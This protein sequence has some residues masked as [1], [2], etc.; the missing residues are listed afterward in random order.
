M[1]ANIDSFEHQNPIIPKKAKFIPTG[2]SGT[3]SVMEEIEIPDITV[4]L[5][6]KDTNEENIPDELIMSGKQFKILNSKMN[7]ILQFLADTGS[8]HYVSGVEVDYL[9]TTQESRLSTLI[10]D[11]DKRNDEMVLNHSRSINGE[12]S[13]LSDVSKELHELL[14]K[15]LE[16]TKV[17]L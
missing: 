2:G 5:S 4:N 1:G 10:D 15:Q 6:N 12:I 14:A 9:L 11:V 17:F 3:K 13:K 7:S 16:E 8:K